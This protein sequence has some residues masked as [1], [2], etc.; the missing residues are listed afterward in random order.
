[1]DAGATERAGT[2]SIS[3]PATTR[4]LASPVSSEM[5]S[6]ATWHEQ[7]E[8]DILARL[9]AAPHSAF[10]RSA[11]EPKGMSRYGAAVG[12]TSLLSALAAIECASGPCSTRDREAA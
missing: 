7:L 8:P 3:P 1:M 2:A 5:S 12:R 10:G 6:P 11:S 4:T 9:R